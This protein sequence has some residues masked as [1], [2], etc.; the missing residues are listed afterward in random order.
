MCECYC[1]FY[2]LLN[3]RYALLHLNKF[4]TYIE[5]L[6]KELEDALYEV[7]LKEGLVDP[8]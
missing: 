2:F 4:K 7:D 6:E 1:L 3:N 8:S 5:L